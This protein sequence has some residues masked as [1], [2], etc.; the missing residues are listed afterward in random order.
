M[1]DLCVVR[2]AEDRCSTV[3]SI[4]ELDELIDSLS[5]QIDTDL[6]L[7]V[8]VEAVSTGNSLAIG[9]GR[10][11]SVLNFVSRSGDP[12]CFTSVGD[13]DADG[14][15]V[16][17]YIGAWSEFRMR[18]VIPWAQARSALRRFAETGRLPKNVEWE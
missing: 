6:P 4:C 13:P 16:F 11:V 1:N 18:S 8:E 9:I 14:T 7:L 10:D 15:V 12:P 3:S 17:F 2:W 5:G